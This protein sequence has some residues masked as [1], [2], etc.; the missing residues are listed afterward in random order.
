MYFK[1]FEFNENF[2]MNCKTIYSKKKK[3]R[4]KSIFKF[5]FQFYYFIFYIQFFLKIYMTNAFFMTN[6]VNLNVL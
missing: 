3:S 4:M 2:L 6:I 5:N 1:K